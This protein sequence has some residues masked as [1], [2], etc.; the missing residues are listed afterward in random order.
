MLTKSIKERLISDVPLG[1]MLSGGLD[2]SVIASI[3]QK[4]SSK[5]INTFSLSFGDGLNENYYANLAAKTIGTNHYE[6][7]VDE[8]KIFPYLYDNIE[9]FDDLGS[10]DPGILSLAF[11][12][13]F[14]RD[15]G[16]KT[17]LFG[18]GADEILAGYKRF[19]LGTLP[20]SILPNKINLMLY[21]YFFSRD[22]FKSL[23]K[24]YKN[25]IPIENKINN[26][27]GSY[28]HKFLKFE[29]EDHLPNNYL[30]KI[31]KSTMYN[32][33]EARV[34]YLDIDLISFLLNIDQKKLVSTNWFFKFE[35]NEKKILRNLAKKYLPQD[36]HTRR[37]FGSMLNTKFFI[38]SNLDKIY[39]LLSG[40]NNTNFFEYFSKKEI[41]N[42]LDFIKKK[43]IINNN[44][45]SF[46]WRLLILLIYLKKNEN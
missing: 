1:V 46:F 29:I 16:I 41:Y 18:E 22:N 39:D 4:L 45:E 28:L 15:H 17:L 30:M 27:N 31:D 5:K 32:S 23:K 21:Y 7:K 13:K 36:I 6:I 3:A 34:P 19:A 10:T 8:K 25:F 33:I 11:S 12:T 2:S 40:N 24:F 37:K 43:K 20:F 44:N 9:V 26:K 14:I 35:G 38:L 42:E